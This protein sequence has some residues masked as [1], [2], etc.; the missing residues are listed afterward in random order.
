MKKQ[1]LYRFFL[2]LCI[3]IFSVITLL[4][5][6]LFYIRAIN[7]TNNNVVTESQ[8]ISSIGNETNMLAFS[9]RNTKNIL[10]NNPYIK[11]VN[12]RK[13]YISREI[14]IDIVERLVIGYIQ[15]SQD[16]FL[17][18]DEEGRVL[19]VNSFFTIPRPILAGLNFSEF[20]L[21]EILEIENEEGF[22][23]VTTLS[24]L[25]D[26]YEIEKDIVR[27][28]VSDSNNIRIYYD[29]IVIN[30]GT[31][32]DIDYKVRIVREVLPELAHMRN[33]GGRL[34]IRYVDRPWIFELLI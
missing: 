28:D 19:E 13:N 24:Y 32:H 27:L 26:I 14:D 17:Y 21:G 20:T 11:D 8:I 9:K 34:D 2:Y 33:I 16:I 1:T 5:S 29:Q 31:M 25:F 15:F 10:L 3:A 4:G 22:Y 6:P 7:I 12:I 18:I 23:I 30:I